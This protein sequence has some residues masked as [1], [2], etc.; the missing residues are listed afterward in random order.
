MLLAP[1]LGLIIYVSASG[2]PGTWQGLRAAIRNILCLALAGLAFLPLTGATERGSQA[3]TTGLGS[4]PAGGAQLRNSHALVLGSS[5]L[6]A[7]G[8]GVRARVT[9]HVIKMFGKMLWPILKQSPIISAR[10][11][12]IPAQCKMAHCCGQSASKGNSARETK[13]ALGPPD[14]F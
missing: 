6:L 8:L 12:F 1:P 4:V 10:Q 2:A 13:S 3:Q 7:S 14:S 11:L 5:K 9:P